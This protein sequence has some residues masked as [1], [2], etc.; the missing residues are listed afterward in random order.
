MFGQS[1][2]TANA[3]VVAQSNATTVLFSHFLQVH[4]FLW[5]GSKKDLNLCFHQQGQ[6]RIWTSDCS[7][8]SYR[9]ASR[10]VV[11]KRE[12]EKQNKCFVKSAV[13]ISH[14]VPTSGSVLCFVRAQLAI[15]ISYLS[16]CMCVRMSVCVH[17]CVY[18]YLHSPS[19][20]D[21]VIWSVNI[22]MHSWIFFLVGK[23]KWQYCF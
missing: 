6:P 16:P 10:L 7:R 21:G 5:W 3:F 17:V 8:D 11:G 20:I 14:S 1:L 18:V 13:V 12:V 22:H 2:D 23:G 9:R 15:S 19:D 4:M